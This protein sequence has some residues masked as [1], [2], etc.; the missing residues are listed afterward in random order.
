MQVT[1]VKA[2]K[3]AKDFGALALED[4]ATVAQLKL[5]FEKHARVSRHRQNFKLQQGD[6]LLVRLALPLGFSLCLLFGC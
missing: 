2:G 4:G 3:K 5:A 6:A 1:V